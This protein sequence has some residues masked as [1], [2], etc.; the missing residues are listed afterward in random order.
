MLSHN[1]DEGI[2][3]ILYG[4]NLCL[5][6][7]MM[8]VFVQLPWGNRA[9][10]VWRMVAK[11]CCKNYKTELAEKFKPAQ[12]CF[13]SKDSCEAVI[14]SLFT[15]LDNGKGQVDLRICKFK[16]TEL[17]NYGMTQTA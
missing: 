7:E 3:D 13:G 15:Y 2:M 9:I 1:V 6:V 16:P 5:Y 14:H 8:M 10:T 12:L 17:Y 4:A 11:T